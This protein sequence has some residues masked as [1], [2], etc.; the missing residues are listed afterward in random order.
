MINGSV[1]TIHKIII[2][3]KG[4]N[5][6]FK[7]SKNNNSNSNSKLAKNSKNSKQMVIETIDVDRILGVDQF[8]QQTQIINQKENKKEER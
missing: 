4:K 3:I 8:I 2:I 6:V 7:Y 1:Q 5:R